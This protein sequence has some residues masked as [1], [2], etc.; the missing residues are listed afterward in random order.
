M[1]TPLRPAFLLALCL[2]VPTAWST[3]EEATQL[4][5]AA[6][7]ALLAGD[8][9]TAVTRYEDAIKADPAN[10]PLQTQY[11]QALVKRINE[12][13]FMLQG[14]LAGKMRHAYERSVEID[15]NHLEGWIGLCR[16]YLN[17]P[18]IAGGSADKAETYA[19]E[20]SRRVP[21]LG[22]VELGLVEEKRGH[23]EAAAEHFRA[24]LTEHPQHGE[25]VAGLARVTAPAP[26]KS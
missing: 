26:A 21:W 18:A 9:K 6:H 15:P 14:M 22:E 3:P 19:W 5:A 23:R 16:Y 25:A 11:A 24:V 2:V 17:A 4:A 7:A 8:T 10:A 13:N 20:V 12:V 1:K